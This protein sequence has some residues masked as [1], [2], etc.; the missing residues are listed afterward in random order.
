MSF[1]SRSPLGACLHLY[2]DELVVGSTHT[3][4]HSLP[5]ITM[6]LLFDFF[7]AVVIFGYSVHYLF[8]SPGL[9]VWNNRSL[10]LARQ[11]FSPLSGD[12]FCRLMYEL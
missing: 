10:K 11:V 5:L 2:A 6:L 12:D 1:L 7:G 8:R 4:P 9:Y 3:T